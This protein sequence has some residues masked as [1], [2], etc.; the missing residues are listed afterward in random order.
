MY[1]AD[2]RCR[3]ELMSRLRI[4]GMEEWDVATNAGLHHSFDPDKPWDWVWNAA[5]NE[6]NFWRMELEEPCLLVISRT[7]PLQTMLDGDANIG[8][9]QAPSTPST[10]QR[11]QKRTLD[12]S[13]AIR[14]TYTQQER[15]HSVKDGEYTCNR[16]GTPLCPGWKDGSCTGTA[17]GARCP[18]DWA[19]AHQCSKCLSSEHGKHNCN[20][21]ATPKPAA[22]PPQ[23]K[24]GKG[25]GKGGKSK[26]KGWKGNN[27]GW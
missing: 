4:R 12:G 26:G 18:K 1:Q 17:T 24:G 22:Q 2:V 10:P 8:T 19:L 23:G 7:T 13:S 21:S 3:Q 20:S 5:V 11:G 16:R 25:K 6:S 15:V 9:G 27:K 14:E